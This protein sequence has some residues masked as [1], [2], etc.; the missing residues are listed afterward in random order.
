[1]RLPYAGSLAQDTQGNLWIGSSNELM[2]WNKDG[3]ARFFG[4]ELEPF[5]AL[6]SVE[7]IAA[8]KDGSVWVAIPRKGLGLFRILQAAPVKYKLPNAATEQANALFVAH[9]DSL[10]AGTINDGIY[11]V[12][13]KRI[14]HFRSE[15]GL[16]SNLINGFYQDREGNLWVATSKGL[17]CFRDNRIVT[18]SRSEGLTADSAA[19]VLATD[20]GDIWFGNRGSLD[21]LHDGEVISIPIP[22]RRVTSLWQDRAKRLW[23]GVDNQLTLY[24]GGEFRRIPRAD[25][26]PIGV[27]REI[28]EDNK[29]NIWVTTT[30]QDHKLFRI[31]DQQAGEPVAIDRDL[32]PH[33][34]AADPEGGVWLRS[35]TTLGHYHTG[36]LDTF[37]LRHVDTLPSG[38]TIDPDRSLWIPTPSG[39]VRW[40]DREIKTMSSRNGLPCDAML[41]DS[42]Q[43]IRPVDLRQVR[44]DSYC[45]YRT[46][47]LVETARHNRTVRIFQRSRWRDTS[48]F[49]IS[50]GCF[51]IA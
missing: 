14:D 29:Q 44:I 41:S 11:R 15:D 18:F 20:D 35:G 7:G 30:G 8:A 45:R 51:K 37:R 23:V 22:G 27:A 19:S 43:S 26:S 5:Q 33:D 40:K 2:R 13:N 17:D 38:L 4:R 10:W 50:P 39:I 42:R 24:D 16:S 28:V 3:F 48:A 32:V 12:Q 46:A 49:Y 36:H 34:L 31:R 25:G 47:T 6:G 1:M 21:R 9:D